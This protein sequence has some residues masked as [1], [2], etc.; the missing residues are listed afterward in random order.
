MKVLFHVLVLL[1]VSAVV[2]GQQL[3]LAGYWKLMPSATQ[4]Q[5]I[6]NSEPMSMG[7]LHQRTN[8]KWRSKNK[9]FSLRFEARSRVFYGSQVEGT[10]GFV[11]SLSLDAGR[12]DGS[13]NWWESDDNKGVANTLIDRACLSYRAGLWRVDLGRQ[14]INWGRH[15]VWNPNDLFNAYNFFDF[16]YAE[17]PGTDALR[18]RRLVG[19]NGMNELEFAIR[20]GG[21][22]RKPLLASLFRW[23][24]GGIDGQIL[25]A[26]VEGAF[27]AGAAASAGWGA[28]GVKAEG[29]FFGPSETWSNGGLISASLGLDAS[30]GEG[31]FAQLA[32]LKSPEAS[33]FLDF[34][35]QSAQRPWQLMPLPWT[36]MV[37]AMI[38][39]GPRARFG[40]AILLAPDDFSDLLVAMPSLTLDAA[41]NLTASLVVQHVSLR[42]NA[43]E[44]PQWQSAS[45]AFYVSLQWDFRRRFQI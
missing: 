29:T 38:P 22:D 43:V 27:A 8:L 35:L 14:R 7:Y 6:P 20:P 42:L 24:A 11:E 1:A 5:V 37:Q 33:G 40:T 21:E 39:M 23:N 41:T 28:F 3:D 10:E 34:S 4:T 19:G 26:R 25:A 16:D 9:R 17:R 45:S 36:G 31:G 15:L 44:I 32:V 12:W 18:L 2:R 30:W 13:W